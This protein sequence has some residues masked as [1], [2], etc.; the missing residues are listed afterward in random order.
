[1]TQ[2]TMPCPCCSLKE[3]DVCCKPYHNGILPENALQLMR[4]RY[5]AY[6]LNLPDYIIFTT[7]PASSQYSN[8][9]FSWKRSISQFSHHSNFQK[10]EILDFKENKTVATVTFTAFLTQNNRDATFTERSF[11]EKMRNQWFYRGG[12]LTRGHAPNLVT[13]GQFRL[14]PLAYYGETILRMKADPINEITHDIKKLIDE[15]IETMDACDGIGLAA[16]Q[17]HHS[18]RLFVI[19]KPIEKD[20]KPF[21]NGEVK[22]F[23]NPQLSLPSIE[24]WMASEGCLSIPTIRAVVERPKE[25]TVEYMTIEGKIITE[26]VSG[27]EARVIMHEYDHIEGILFIDRLNPEEQAKL[28]PFLQNLEK[29]I[30]DGQAL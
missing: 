18:I 20:Q 2:L 15:M 27:W 14:L 13:T 3:Y 26:R 24:T 4:S 8:N 6:V 25:I 1:M 7:H 30:H 17:I 28:L 21:E 5:S 16:P 11:F 19:R 23:I 9:K 29:R 22:V 10:L 12:Q